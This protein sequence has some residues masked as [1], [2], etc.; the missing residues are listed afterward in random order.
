ML[1]VGFMEMYRSGVVVC[2][3]D[4]KKPLTDVPAALPEVVAG[5]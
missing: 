3:F 2:S 1:K 4:Y 5:V